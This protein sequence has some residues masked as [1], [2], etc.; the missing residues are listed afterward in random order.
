MTTQEYRTEIMRR[1]SPYRAQHSVNVAKEAVQLAEHYGADPNSAE[2]A[3]LLHD[4]MKET[5]AKEQ[6]QLLKEFDIIYIK[7]YK[8]A[9]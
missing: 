3:G 5:P 2:I 1:L 9:I 6:L 8:E 4:C 7:R